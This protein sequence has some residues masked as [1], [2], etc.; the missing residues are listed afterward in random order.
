MHFVHLHSHSE[1]SIGDGLFSPKKWVKALKDKRFVGHALTDHGTM[2][3]TLLFDKVMREEGLKPVHGCEFYF[4]PDPTDKI[5]ENRSSAHLVLLAKSYDG[6]QNLLQLQ[7][8]AYGTG[9]Y[10]KPRIGWEILEKHCDDLVCLTACIGG[11]LAKEG[12]KALE[13]KPHTFMDTYLR[14]KKL[15]LHD[16]YVEFQG[17]R[18]EKQQIMNMLYID[19]L[20]DLGYRPV[21]TNDCHYILPEHFKVQQLVKN[22][23]FKNPEAAASYAGFDSCYLKTGY[24][25][26]ESFKR[27][28]EEMPLAVVAAGVRNTEKIF[29]KCLWEFPT[30]KHYLPK[31][32]DS[33]DSKDLFKRLTSLALVEFLRGCDFKY[34]SRE[35]YLERFVKEYKVIKKYGLQDY[36]LIVWDII[37]FAKSKS[38]YMGVGRGSSAGSFIAYLLKIVKI[39]PLQYGLIFERFLNEI[40]CESGELPDVDL[41]SESDRRQE[42]KDY[43]FKRYG[44]DCVCEIGIYGRLKLKSSI[45]DFGKAFGFNHQELTALTTKLELDKDE[46]QSL[47][48]AMDASPRLEEIMNSNPDLKFAVEEVNGQIKSQG[49]HPAGVIITSEPYHQITPVKTQKLRDPERAKREGERIFVTQCEDKYVVAQGIVKMD[50]LGIKEYDIFKSIIETDSELT[51]DNYIDVIHQRAIDKSDKKVWDFFREGKSEGVFQFSGQGM[52]K[53]LIDMQADCLEDLI[54]AVALYRPGC[55]ANDWH[56]LYCDRKHGREP[57]VYL[58]PELEPILGQTYGVCVFQEMFMKTFH[59]IGGIPMSES[60]VIRSALGKKD[61][62]KLKK[63]KAEFVRN[64]SKKLDDEDKAEELWDQIKNAS[65]YAFNKAHATVYA[66]IAYISQH[67]KANNTKAFWAAV[68]SWDAK[69]NKIEDLAKNRK[70]AIE[71]EVKIHLPSINRSLINFACETDGIRWSLA[72]IKGVGPKTVQEIISKK[73]YKDLDDFY[74]RVHKAKVKFDAMISVAYAGTFDEFGD[75]KEIINKLYELKG[76]TPPTLT[77]LHMIFKFYEIM[78]FFEEKLRRICPEFD[79]ES[80]FDEQTVIDTLSGEK[81]YAGGMLIDTRSFK[82]KTGNTMGKAF[83]VDQDESLEL[84]FFSKTWGAYRSSIR[85]GNLMVVFGRKSDYGGR[86]NQIEVLSVEEIEI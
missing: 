7:K 13:D 81:V 75:R 85:D 47:D 70:A 1:Y 35:E 74:K 39:D 48:A 4:T 18:D 68:L 43:V 38:I 73:P 12:W 8:Y 49:I 23:A 14:L 25:V 46:A 80:I 6:F 10:Y 40:R 24:E 69:K 16:L 76:Q 45:L 71:M 52:Q 11:I 84:T 57:I 30:G 20:G 83:L 55:L 60:D 79:H 9:Y 15:F 82:D 53:L 64:A 78:G 86:E 5:P 32:D 63:F 56:T 54:A 27:Y 34:A 51:V 67:F 61:E 72:G 59:V 2:A 58:H 28:H 44:T 42:I 21:I 33:I 31:F 36:F 19:Q 77:D 17:H 62:E 29:D 22:N 50:F 26:F 66:L 37:R 3:G 65:G 41:D